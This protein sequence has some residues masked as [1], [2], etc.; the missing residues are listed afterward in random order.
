MKLTSWKSKL[1]FND[2]EDN[3][4][5]KSANEYKEDESEGIFYLKRKVA[6]EVFA[7][8]I[9]KREHDDPKVREAMGEELSKWVKFDAYEVVEDTPDIVN[10]IDS[11]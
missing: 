11:K 4:T 2:T 7:A 3:Q 9:H 8:E 10:K 1:S 5:E 6:N